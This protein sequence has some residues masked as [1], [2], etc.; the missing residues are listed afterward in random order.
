ML[1]AQPVLPMEGRAAMMVSAEILEATGHAV[2]LGVMGSE[3]RDLLPLLV[4]VVDGA[5]RVADNFRD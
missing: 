3:A 2:K 4:K 1:M 5:E